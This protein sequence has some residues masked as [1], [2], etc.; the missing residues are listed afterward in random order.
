MRLRSK[1]TRLFR[2]PAFSRRT[3]QSRF[4]YFAMDLCSVMV[5]PCF[6]KLIQAVGMRLHTVAGHF[7]QQNAS[8][9]QLKSNYQQ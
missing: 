1:I 7:Q 9:L 3:I 8:I 2:T 4:M 6:K 5:Q